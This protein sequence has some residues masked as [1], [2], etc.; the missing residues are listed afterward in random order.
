MFSDCHLFYTFL[1]CLMLQGFCFEK[2]ISMKKIFWLVVLSITNNSRID[3]CFVYAAF[4]KATLQTA[5]LFR[6][7]FEIIVIY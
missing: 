5:N 6:L 3:S 4:R 1:S 2:F 7:H